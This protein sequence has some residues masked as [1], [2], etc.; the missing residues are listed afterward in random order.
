MGVSY[1]KYLHNCSYFNIS[2]SVDPINKFNHNCITT[3][4]AQ[5]KHLLYFSF[6]I[7]DLVVIKIGINVVV[8]SDSDRIT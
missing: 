1:L 3:V 8:H 5:P 2:T 4:I 7:L 6:L